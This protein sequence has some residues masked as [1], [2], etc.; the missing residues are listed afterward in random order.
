MSRNGEQ[1]PQTSPASATLQAKFQQGLALHQQGR[2]A[3]AERAYKEILWQEPRH[4]GALHLLGV[5]ALQTHRTQR[6]VELIVKA[7]EIDPNIAAAHGNLGSALS[8][9]KHPQKA[10]AS[11]DKAIALKPRL[12]RGTQQSR[13]CAQRAKALR[14]SDRELRQSDRTK[15]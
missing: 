4:F 8:A 3:E 2:F 10:L 11:Y 15:A 14:G 7:I 13:K 9:L 12:R 6:S 1:T 5:V